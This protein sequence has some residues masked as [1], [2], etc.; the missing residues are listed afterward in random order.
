MDTTDINEQV[1]AA[2]KFED[3][4]RQRRIANGINKKGARRYSNKKG[5][6]VIVTK[7]AD[8]REYKTKRILQR[9]K[10][11]TLVHYISV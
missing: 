4:R 5:V 2:S 7:L 11:R 10:N 1:E 3:N 9:L 6:Q 8:G